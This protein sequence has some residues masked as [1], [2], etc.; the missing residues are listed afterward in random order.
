MRIP[1]D[2]ACKEDTMLWPI[3]ALMATE[4][5]V[6]SSLQIT[7]LQSISRDVTYHGRGSMLSLVSAGLG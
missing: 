2:S 7:V 5:S 6:I 4:I 3:G 1:S